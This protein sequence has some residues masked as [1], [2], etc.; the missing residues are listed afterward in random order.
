MSEQCAITGVYLTEQSRR[1]ER[2]TASL[3]LE[4]ILGAL[5][6]ANLTVK[7]VDGISARWDG[8]GGAA[9]GHSGSPDWATLLG[10]E[11][12]W[13]GDTYP[14][15][16]PGLMDAVAAIQAG[17]CSTVVVCGGQAGVHDP[18]G[19][20]ASYT[21]PEN[22]FSA[23]WGSSTPAQF[24]LVARRYL[25]EYGIDVSRIAE[26]SVAVRNVGSSNPEAVM[27][28]RGPYTEQDVLASPMIASPFH[29]LDL[30]LA[31][32]GAAAFVV[33]SLRRARGAGSQPVTVL[34]LAAEWRRQQYVN[35][36]RYD[37]VGKLGADAGQRALS[38]AG[39]SVGDIDVM[40]LYD[41][42]AFEIVRQVEL[43]GLC[44]EGEGFDYLKE[45]GINGHHGPAFNTDG[46]LLSFSHIGRSAP[47]LKLVEAV[48]QLR[49]TAALPVG[50]RRETALFSGA[51]SAA[52]Y[53]NVAVLG[54]D[55]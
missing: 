32:D 19:A 17:Y 4:A 24:A 3:C 14:A 48:R 2:M 20:V 38:A 50:R 23:P 26:V 16:V 47:T 45:R 30:C 1:I 5:K 12:Q 55:R 7:D 29:L 27:R 54:I 21:R 31:T 18:G 43:L 28:D 11:M 8:P 40:E 6:D 9:T 39:I 25:Y 51:G 46:G 37:E 49:G 10:K 53:Y 41:P 44:A 33:T 36:P 34:G 13:I 15:G 52:Q 22:E 35:S 42:N